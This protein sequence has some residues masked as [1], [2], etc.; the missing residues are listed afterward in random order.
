MDIMI[1]LE[2]II[3]NDLNITLNSFLYN[4]ISLFKYSSN[5]LNDYIINKCQDNPLIYVDEEKIPLSILSYKNEIKDDDTLSEILQYFNCSLSRKDQLT[6]RYIIYS[7]NSNGF[8]EADTKEISSIMNTTKNTVE[9]LIDLLQNYDNRGIGCKNIIDFLSF[10]LKYKKIYN[11]N[12]FSVFISQMSSIQKQDYSFL[13]S[14]DVN[15]T[16][17]LSYVDLIKDSCELSPIN[18]EDI[19]YLTPDASILLDNN[20]N[21]VIQIHDYLLDSVTFEP[22]DLTTA[23][24]SFARKIES[25]KNDYEEL[26]SIL[27]ARKVYLSDILV[28]ISNVQNDYLMGNTSFLNTLDQNM[29][30]DYTSLSPATISRLLHNKFI[31][32]PRGILPIKFLL[33][34]KCYKNFSVSYVKYLIQ[35][36]ADFE[37]IPDNKISGILNGQGIS[38]S[39]RTVNKYKNQLLGQI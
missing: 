26:V 6:M 9:Y 14:I 21:F 18:H 22:I 27:N 10:Q 5:E 32:T 19:T 20:N 17:F 15:E 33:S 29:L 13:K 1:K 36:L 28:I 24:H 39:R 34:K 11:E 25:Y 37:N 31:S 3:T 2:N 38:I 8:L 12:L 23:E 7:L 4:S 16:D 30:S 35:N